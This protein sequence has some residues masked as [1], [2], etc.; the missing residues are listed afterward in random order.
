MGAG[1]EHFEVAVAESCFV[2]A[3]GGGGWVGRGYVGGTPG[4]TAAMWL[5]VPGGGEA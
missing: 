4:A 5:C 2:G 3:G 1:G